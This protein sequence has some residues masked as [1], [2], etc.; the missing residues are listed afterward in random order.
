MFLNW[1]A[2]ELIGFESPSVGLASRNLNYIPD[3]TAP[4]EC[5][6]KKENYI[7]K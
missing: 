3:Q 6:Y 2:L 5:M 4:R 1:E 7:P